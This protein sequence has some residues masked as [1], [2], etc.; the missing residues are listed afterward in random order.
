[1]KLRYQLLALEPKAKKKHA[2][3]L[4]DESDMDDEFMERHE[5]E[6]L[7]KA[8]TAAEKKFEKDNVKLE[9]SNEKKKPKSELD[10]RLKEIKAEFKALAKERKTK[11]VEP[12]T[13][14][15]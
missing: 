3:L 9:D 13:G 7:E 15:E 1:M 5:E 11:K 8:L 4:E 6:L 14:G 10:D 2:E 12:K